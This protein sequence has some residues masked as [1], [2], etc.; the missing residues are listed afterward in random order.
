VIGM[1]GGLPP[2]N[3]FPF[4]SFHCGLLPLGDHEAAG[5]PPAA[6]AGDAASAQQQQ[7]VLTIDDPHA[8]AAAQ[9]YNMQ[10][11]VC[12]QQPIQLRACPQSG[13]LWT[14]AVWGD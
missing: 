2:S 3:T 8:V 11:Q 7:N 9:Q 5:K 4:T 14:P 6:A 1:H 13:H 12:P 10:A